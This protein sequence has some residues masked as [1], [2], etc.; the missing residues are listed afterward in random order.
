ME[1]LADRI[2]RDGPV[3][4][5]DAVGW[6]IRLAKRLEALHVLGVAHGSVS[7]AC[8]IA[9][10]VER[11]AKAYLADV[12][13]TTSMPSFQSPE[14]IVGGDLSPADDTWAVAAT[15]YTA[16]TGQSPFEGAT[17]AE[18]RQKIL[19]ASPPPLA[20]FDAGDDDLQ[21]ILDRAF[22]RDLGA[23]TVTVNALRRALEEWHPDPNVGALLPLDDEETSFDGDEPDEQTLARP[24]LAFSKRRANA[25][26]D[27][28]DDDARTLARGAP[29]GPSAG[30]RMAAALLPGPGVS[31]LAV[32]AIKSVARDE[33]DDNER[34]VMRNPQADDGRR[35]ARPVGREP[36][37][38]GWPPSPGAPA[39][40]GLGDVRNERPLGMP[41]GGAF[42]PPRVGDAM[43]PLPSPLVAG[44]PFSASSASSSALLPA[45]GGGLHPAGG[46]PGLRGGALDR[47]R[48]NRTM[49]LA[50]LLALLVAAMLTFA[51][52]R[53]GAHSLLG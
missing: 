21:Q 3:K 2:T 53:Y 50:A 4:E 47:S 11:T 19:A 41:A 14:R 5:L 40:P 32:T 10:G 25:A 33:D 7:P 52:L 43:R 8:I 37:A 48:S 17:E 6:A 1:T 23:R 35:G 27:A 12:Q 9:I 34:T 46:P 38:G 42:S 31:P 22:D 45:S 20:V 18:V 28:A 29:F 30:L 39:W 36:S 16:L 24:M 51:F 26:D 49:L 44:G 13:L 15:L